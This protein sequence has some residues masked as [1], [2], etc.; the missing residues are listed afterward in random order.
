[1]LRRR[2]HSPKKDAEGSTISVYTYI[3]SVY[4]YFTWNLY[5]YSVYLYIC[6]DF[7]IG[8]AVSKLPEIWLVVSIVK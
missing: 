5:I 2:S 4:I 7:P 3:Y 6:K 8:V 1:M